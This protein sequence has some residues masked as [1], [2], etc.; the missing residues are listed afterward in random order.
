MPVVID[1][2]SP[3]ASMAPVLRAR[4]VRVLVTSAQDMAKACGQLVD[5]IAAGAFT[6]ADQEPVNRAAEGVRKRA[7][8]NAGGWGYDRR[9]ESP[10]DIA[11]IV[12]MT[13]ALF[14]ALATKRRRS[15]NGRG[16]GATTGRRAAIL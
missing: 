16:S 7:I 1:G 15:G 12:A 8:G 10:V 2:A 6:H 3:A 13:L 4:G 9:E 14:G 11:P 5:K